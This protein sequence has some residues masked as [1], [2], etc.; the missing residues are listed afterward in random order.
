MPVHT[1]RRVT[2]IPGQPGARFRHTAHAPAYAFEKTPRP[3]RQAR[4]HPRGR[5]GHGKH[6]RCHDTPTATTPAGIIS[7]NPRFLYATEA[8]QTNQP[9]LTIHQ[10]NQFGRRQD[11]LQCVE[12]TR[13]PWL[14]RPVNQKSTASGSLHAPPMPRSSSITCMSSSVNSK[15]N[16]S[17]FDRIRFICT[18]FGSGNTSCCN[19]QRT[20]T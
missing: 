15:S 16:T 3:A 19:A 6:I 2:G 13:R 18:D 9:H 20:Q 11:C 5:Q 8:H 10:R 12:T 7:N 17:I 1:Q 14:Y 4:L